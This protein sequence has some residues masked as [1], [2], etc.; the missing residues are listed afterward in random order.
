MRAVL[1]IFCLWF[2]HN[3]LAQTQCFLLKENTRI[4][5]Q[6]GDCQTRHSPNSTFK[7]P[8]SLMG[9]NEG[10]LINQ[11]HPVWPFKAEYTDWV[12]T[13]AWKDPQTP[14]TWMRDSVVW[15]SQLITQKLGEEKFGQYVKAFQ[16]GNQDISGGLT[17]AWLSSSLKISPVEQIDFLQKL[18]NDALPVSQRSQA[19]TRHILFREGLP[20]GWKLYGKTGSG[21]LDKTHS[22]GWFV[23]WL[24]KGD[25]RIIFAHYIKIDSAPGIYAGPVAKEMAIEKLMKIL[26]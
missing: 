25:R 23:G 5:A 24:E 17:Q 4:L 2:S 8:I 14:R 12:Y 6:E 11:T 10:I 20:N 1:F 13:E 15:Y 19:L 3:L 16:Y 18:L 22:G 9:F 26:G 21:S 7:I